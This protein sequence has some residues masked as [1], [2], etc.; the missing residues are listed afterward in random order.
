MGRKSMAS[1]N[2]MES[3]KSQAMMEMLESSSSPGESPEALGESLVKAAERGTRERARDLLRR[4]A[5]VD[6]A[7]E[8]GMAGLGWAAHNGDRE[9]ARIFLE[10]G[11]DPKRRD[12]TGRTPVEWA[13][14]KGHVELEWELG[15]EMR[16]G[17]PMEGA[18]QR[19]A[20]LAIQM[21]SE[22][23]EEIGRLRAGMEG[24]SEQVGE[25][26]GQ[27]GELRDLL[28]EAL[29]LERVGEEGPEGR[30]RDRR[31]E[32]GPRSFGPGRGR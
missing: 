28:R 10:A 23:K 19:T 3:E 11:A 2:W 26:R 14:K 31:G 29:G 18:K 9:M 13:R 8:T 21:Q 20:L 12:G 1:M 30:V 32:E 27:V 25:L 24:L 16:K 15:E 17:G 5:P 22:A 4:G 7:D 6:A